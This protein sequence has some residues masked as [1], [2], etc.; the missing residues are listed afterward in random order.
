VVEI[1]EKDS[2]PNLKSDSE[3]NG[4]RLIIDA[5]PTVIVM[6][7]IIQPKEIADLEEGEHHFHPQMWVKGSP[8]H[9]F[10]IAEARR[11]SSQQRSSK[12]WDYRQHHTHNHT[13]SGGFTKDEMSVSANN[14][15]YPMESILSRMR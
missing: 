4:R 15:A 2:N 3:N 5:K 8:L 7:T 13:T 14:V 9:F 11:I 6:T 12:N 10:F 1:K